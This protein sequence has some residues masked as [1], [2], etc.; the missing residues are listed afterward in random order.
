MKRFLFG[1]LGAI[2]ATAAIAYPFSITL[3]SNSTAST[4]KNWNGGIGEFSAVAS[5][6]NS[7]TATLE[8]LGPD[9]STYVAAGSNTT[10]TANC[11]GVFYLPPGPIKVVISG[12]PTG[13]YA[14]AAQVTQP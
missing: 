11:A 9:G 8:F 6:W 13:L 7:A 1:F 2:I 5:N 14:A 4:A 3:V 10:C 12:S